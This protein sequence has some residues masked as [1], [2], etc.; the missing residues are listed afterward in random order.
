VALDWP[1]LWLANFAEDSCLLC[2][3]LGKKT[4]VMQKKETD[5]F[6]KGNKTETN[7]TTYYL[8]CRDPHRW[9]K[10]ASKN[11]FDNE[12]VSTLQK[13]QNDKSELLA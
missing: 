5:V 7:E 4:T 13:N 2:Y 8:K 12:V 1:Y 6:Q 11:G 10:P 9:C 3:R